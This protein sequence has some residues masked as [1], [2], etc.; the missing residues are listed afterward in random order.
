MENTQKND[1][2]VFHSRRPLG[3]VGIVVLKLNVARLI[4][5]D[6]EG[7]YIPLFNFHKDTTERQLPHSDRA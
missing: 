2:S 4:R 3:F 7:N 5:V 6:E 1:S